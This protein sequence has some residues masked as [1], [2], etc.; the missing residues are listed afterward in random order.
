MHNK[1]KYNIFEI[2]RQTSYMPKL[3]PIFSNGANLEV[4]TNKK[5]K[6]QINNDIKQLFPKL[7]TEYSNILEI[8]K[9]ITKK[10]INK[11]LNIGII[12]SGGP[13]PGGHNVISGL[14]DAI[15][16][17][18]KNNKLF[19]FLNG[20]DGII[21]DH[22]IE[23]TDVLLRHYR[24]TGGFDMLGTSRTKLHTEEQFKIITKKIK[25]MQINS[26]VIIGGDDSNTNAAKLAEY[27]LKN[28]IKIN[29]I[30]C[31]K[32]ID[33]D[34]KNRFIE[35]TFGF[36]TACKTYSNLISNIQ[37]DI[38][39]SKKHWHFVRL[40]GRKA[41]HIALE[42]A[43]Q[44]H[45]NI[46]I[47]SEEIVHNKH[48]MLDLIRYISTIILERSKNGMNYGIVLLPEGLIE[49]IPETKKLIG[50]IKIIINK[51]CSYIQKLTETEL[52]EYIG[53]HKLLSIESKTFYNLLSPELK[54]QFLVGTDSHGNLQITNIKI[55]EILVNLISK[56]LKENYKIN[57]IESI[58]KNFVC[59][60]FGY[61]GRCA[62]PSNFD[63]TYC[64]NLGYTIA[65]LIN[66]KNTGYIAY[67][68]NLTEDISKWTFGSL[69]IISMMH[70]TERNNSKSTVIKTTLVNIKSKSYLE[71]QKYKK[72]WAM[73]DSYY[74]IPP[75]QYFGSDEICETKPM[76]LLIEYK[77]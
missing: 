58:C 22:Y 36:D 1:D 41:S 44:T 68:K 11:P 57:N 20:S 8:S 29:V 75:T 35:T 40:M 53:Q 42:C 52:I 24:N 46:T 65:S 30:G 76:S 33:C 10:K 73:T 15:K 47:I 66:S 69:P 59:H 2:T 39:S 49:F 27:F 70:I 9:Q 14:F 61:E 54:K 62:T 55:D 51:D 31:P 7:S 13:A 64:Y 72:Q 26:L 3:S 60:F 12:F 17:I 45:P 19:G 37:K 48:T 34:L 5:D 23:I 28:N 16:S 18:H 38:L 32:T 56:Y 77:K 74:L 50:E 43:L 63:A 6:T 67:I 25:E 4:I 21:N 71:L